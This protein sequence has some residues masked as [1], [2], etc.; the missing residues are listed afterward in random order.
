MKQKKESRKVNGKVSS[1]RSISPLLRAGLN[2]LLRFW[3]VN[4]SGDFS[5]QEGNTPTLSPDLSLSL[6]L[7]SA[8]VI[9]L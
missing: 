3:K 1:W 4:N 8:L 7:P 2:L 5:E 6:F 9:S